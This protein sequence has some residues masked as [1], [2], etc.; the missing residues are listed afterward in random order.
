MGGGSMIQVS[1]SALL[2]IGM[3]VGIALLGI[4]WVAA[5]LRQRN[6]E[7]RVREDLVSCRICGN[8]YDNQQKQNLTACPK[9]GSLNE[10]LKPKPI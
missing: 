10:A 6:F 3:S 1:L 8:I 5:V 2:L 7:K 4:V 9:C